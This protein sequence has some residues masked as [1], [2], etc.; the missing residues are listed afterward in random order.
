MKKNELMS[1]KNM[2]R[3]I[4]AL[5]CVSALGI[6]GISAFFTDA[7]G[8]TNTFTVGKVEQTF[9]E[10]N[11]APP[12]NIT[13][14][15]EVTK[16]PTATNT[17]INDQYVFMTVRVPYSNIVTANA[18]GTKNALAETELFSYTIDSNWAEL[19]SG[20]KD[21]DTNTVT[22]TYYYGQNDS[23]KALKKGE[24]TTLFNKVKFVNAV[25]GQ[26]LED[27]QQDIDINSFA[28]QTSN[29][30]TATTPA[31]VWDLLQ[32]QTR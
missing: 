24:K 2:K 8:R 15:E 22:H 10:P 4:V 18:D 17:G 1:K 31:Q 7:D 13:P 25:E 19:G 21:A 26:D 5:C 29:L 11:F 14:G 27:T 28:I 20:Q 16:D 6:A 12:E 30:G 23:L 9:D 32:K 3:G